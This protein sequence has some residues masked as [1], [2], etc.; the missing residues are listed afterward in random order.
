[1]FRHFALSSHVLTCA[2]LMRCEVGSLDGTQGVVVRG[3]VGN[4]GSRHPLENVS[5]EIAPAKFWKPV[6][7]LG[8]WVPEGATSNDTVSR[9]RNPHRVATTPFATTPVVL[10]TAR[11]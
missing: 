4:L 6:T 11:G 8:D 10:S 2:L 3:V 1:M 7:I 5:R 9:K